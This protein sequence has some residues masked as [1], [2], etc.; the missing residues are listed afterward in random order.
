MTFKIHTDFMGLGF[1]YFTIICYMGSD[2]NCSCFFVFFYY[3]MRNLQFNMNIFSQIW[4]ATGNW[5]ELRKKSWLIKSN[6]RWPL[7]TLKSSSQYV[8][9]IVIIEIFDSWYLLSTE[10][11]RKML[12]KVHCK[13]WLFTG[14][15]RTKMCCHVYGSLHGCVEPS[16]K[17]IW[18]P[19]PERE[20][21]KIISQKLIST[22]YLGILHFQ[23]I[24]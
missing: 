3:F 22:C 9:F 21:E 7:S 10:N 2:V 6:S 15:F 4:M 24:M 19:T 14:L 5:Q 23:L 8:I 1:Q 16:L 12:Q 11:V 13:T 20:H 18:K 17:S